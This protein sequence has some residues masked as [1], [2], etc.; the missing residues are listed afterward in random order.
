MD[1]RDS[2]CTDFYPER[3]KRFDLFQIKVDFSKYRDM[4]INRVL[5]SDAIY[6]YLI[7]RTRYP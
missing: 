2:N 3:I 7:K 6:L 4:Q 5:Y 1:T